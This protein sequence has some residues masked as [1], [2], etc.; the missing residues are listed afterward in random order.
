MYAEFWVAPL[1]GAWIETLFGYEYDLE[2]KVAPLVGAWIETHNFLL[3][4]DIQ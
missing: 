3:C 2:G 1:V 4:R